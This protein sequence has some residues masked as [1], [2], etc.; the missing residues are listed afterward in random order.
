MIASYVMY[1]I[2][3]KLKCDFIGLFRIT[4]QTIAQNP[5]ATFPCATFLAE[6]C[7]PITR[8]AIEQESC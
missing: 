5:C 8:Q 3:H 7:N 2:D 1:T 4:A 6:L